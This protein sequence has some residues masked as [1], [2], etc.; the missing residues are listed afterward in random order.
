VITDRDSGRNRGFGFVEMADQ[1]E[2]QAAMNALNGSQLQGRTI[3][4]NESRPRTDRGQ[5]SGR[6][7]F[8]GGSRGGRW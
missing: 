8:G 7:G 2:A 3:V 1:A 6:A 4:V 5:T